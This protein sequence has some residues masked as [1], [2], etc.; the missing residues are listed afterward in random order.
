MLDLLRFEWTNGGCATDDGG[1]YKP[2]P[3]GQLDSVD[4]SDIE[5]LRRLTV[6]RAPLVRPPMQSGN[7]LRDGNTA[8][9]AP[10]DDMLGVTVA[11]MAPQWCDRAYLDRHV[12]AWTT[13]V[14]MLQRGLHATAYLAIP[15]LLVRACTYLVAPGG[16]GDIPA[17]R[18]ATW[19]ERGLAALV[20]AALLEEYGFDDVM[21]DIYPSSGADLLATWAQYG[22]R[23][24]IPF[25][26]RVAGHVHVAHLLVSGHADVPLSRRQ[27][28]A[29]LLRE[30]GAWLDGLI[31]TRPVLLFGG[32][33][34]GEELCAM[35]ERDIL[36]L[37]ADGSAGVL[38]VNRGGFLVR[39]WRSGRYVTIRGR[40]EQKK[41]M[42]EQLLEETSVELACRIGRVSLSVRRLL[43]LEPGQVLTLDTPVGGIVDVMCGER[44][45]A[46]GELV[47]V[48]G[49]VGI[50]ITRIEPFLKSRARN[51]Q[52]GD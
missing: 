33:I 1:V 20:C 29:T 25:E 13:S 31:A 46:R 35:R 30:R 52:G 28:A 26:V 12:G 10:T 39:V 14:L 24:S 9:R 43:E 16:L 27:S 32:V 8:A 7:V 48:S 36:A 21:V 51:P 34:G 3:W 18:P 15:S 22:P 50:R 23:F 11:A 40:Y 41:S 4:V 42:S 37:D 44:V 38:S 47:D 45:I 49:S 2:Y 6:R 17:P 5:L 19:S